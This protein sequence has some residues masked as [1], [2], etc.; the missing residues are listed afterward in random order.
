MAPNQVLPFPDAGPSTE[1]TMANKEGE[2]KFKL[3]LNMNKV[4]FPFTPIG[5]PSYVSLR[6]HNPLPHRI[7]YKVRCTSAEV[8]RVQP[9][10]AFVNP[11]GCST[12]TIWNANTS[13]KE[14]MEKRH[15]FAFYHK[16]ASP[17]ARLAPPLWKSGL[18]DAE[19]VRRIPVVFL[20]APGTAPATGTTPS[21]APAQ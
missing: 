18:K 7:T 10:V 17:S 16:A 4:E 1:E 19:G 15:Y 20:P 11:N 21:A 9:P 6:L 8:F 14:K 2:P 5:K 12:I 13:D 3:S